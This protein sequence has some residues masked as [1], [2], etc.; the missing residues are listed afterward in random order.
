MLLLLLCIFFLFNWN[1]EFCLSGRICG[2][3]N[4]STRFCWFFFLM[5][6]PDYICKSESLLIF[7]QSLKN[8]LFGK[9]F[10]HLNAF[11]CSIMYASKK[12][13]F[14]L[15]SF[16]DFNRKLHFFICVYW[17]KFTSEWQTSHVFLNADIL[18]WCANYSHFLP[19]WWKSLWTLEKKT[20]EKRQ[21]KNKIFDEKTIVDNL[22][23]S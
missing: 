18:I 7:I 16:C 14:F 21:T 4:F 23:V 22:T 9:V 5:T 15:S 11:N 13:A 2:S 3:T 19:V 8:V 17:Q 10:S 12:I 6:K 20:K 1:Y